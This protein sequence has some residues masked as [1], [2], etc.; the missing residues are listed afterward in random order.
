MFYKLHVKHNGMNRYH[1]IRITIASS[2]HI[3][4]AEFV[5]FMYGDNAKIVSIAP[6]L[7]SQ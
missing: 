5:K 3:V 7:P 2:A 6:M 4:A 1:S